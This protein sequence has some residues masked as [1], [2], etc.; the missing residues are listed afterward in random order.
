MVSIFIGSFLPF[1][2]LT[3]LLSVHELGHFL[4]AYFLGVPVVKIC[5]Y[6]Y[7]GVSV[8]NIS[9]NES[10]KK[11][12]IILIMGPIFQLICFYIMISLPFFENYIS[13]LYIYNYSLLI[14]N[15][16]P[17]YPLDG[18]KLL[19]LLLSIKFSFKRSLIFTLYFSYF[20][21]LLLTV[22]FLPSSFKLNSF[23]IIILLLYKLSS[24]YKKRN[25]YFEKFLLERYLNNYEY[26]KKIV[27]SINQFMRNRTHIIQKNNR[28]YTEREILKTRFSLK[29]L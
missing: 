20:L 17:I 28:Y 26:K 3:I 11:E 13:L 10:I 5:F 9:L 21:I 2:I 1:I 27:K 4:A 22:I 24:E 23:L 16:L 18:G 14:F 25:Y 8:F 7:G 12:F 15:L 6:P 19:N 29:K